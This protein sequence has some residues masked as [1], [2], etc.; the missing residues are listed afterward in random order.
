ME[1]S[2]RRRLPVL[3]CAVAIV[4]NAVPVLA[5]PVTV[6]RVTRSITVQSVAGNDSRSAVDSDRSWLDTKRVSTSGADSASVGASLDTT[7][8]TPTELAASGNTFVTHRSVGADSGGM[9]ESS[10]RVEFI[11]TEPLHFRFGATPS[12]FGSGS[13]SMAVL[14]SDDDDV[15]RYDGSHTGPL[16]RGLLA[17]GRYEF[18]ARAQSVA[19]PQRGTGRTA[20]AFD[21]ALGLEP[22]GSGI[23]WAGPWLLVPAAVLINFCLTHARRP[24][25]S[26][27]CPGPA[28]RA[29]RQGGVRH[30]PA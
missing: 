1:G 13:W 10:F 14:R 27:R 21:F 16:A 6:V 29:D 7:K 26:H 22:A 9:A 15:F 30:R 24:P 19:F 25:R 3:W 11:V 23:R 28:D 5:D 12:A 17:P 20:A 18:V 4:V 8:I 2:M